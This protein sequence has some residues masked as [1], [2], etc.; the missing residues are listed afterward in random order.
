M[1]LTGVTY[2]VGDCSAIISLLH[3][4]YGG[5]PPGRVRNPRA[6]RPAKAAM[7]PSTDL[8][9]QFGEIDI[10]LFDQLVRGRFDGRRRILDAGCGGGRNLPYFLARGFEVYAIDE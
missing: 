8:R 4:H 7:T 2:S 6:A 9:A 5:H 3:G 10:Y 1:V